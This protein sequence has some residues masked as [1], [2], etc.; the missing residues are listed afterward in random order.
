MLLASKIVSMGSMDIPIK[1]NG[2]AFLAHNRIIVGL[3]WRG[4]LLESML[5]VIE[6][7]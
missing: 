6:V 7:H 2:I 4:L 3:C 5:Q 1:I